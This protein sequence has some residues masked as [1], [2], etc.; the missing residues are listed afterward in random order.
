M[1]LNFYR[2]DCNDEHADTDTFVQSPSIAY[3]FV[4]FVDFNQYKKG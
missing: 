3:A 1:A 2:V 4:C